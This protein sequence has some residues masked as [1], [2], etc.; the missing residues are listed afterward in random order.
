VLLWA[1][2]SLIADCQRFYG[3]RFKPGM[4]CAG[5]LD[6]SVDSCQGDSGGPLVC[7]DELGVS[8]LWGI[9]SWGERCGHP[10][11]PGVYTQ[12]IMSAFSL[13]TTRGLLWL[14]RSLCFMC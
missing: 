12:V 7:E 2:V 9:V 8:Y 10:G 6:G 1:N 3:D 4:M 13:L 11:F 14:Y 5:D